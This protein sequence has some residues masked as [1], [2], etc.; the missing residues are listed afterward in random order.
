[1]VVE[2]YS[3]VMHMVSHVR[4]RLDAGQGRGFDVL[5]AASRPAR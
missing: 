5:R 2:R 3:H 1:M 4:G